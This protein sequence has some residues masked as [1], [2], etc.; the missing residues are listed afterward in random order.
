MKR[1]YH[2]PYLGTLHEFHLAAKLGTERSFT[3]ENRFG[4]LGR[5]Q[6]AILVLLNQLPLELRIWLLVIALNL[7]MLIK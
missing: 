5:V 7:K 1:S 2:I 4:N 3:S 6:V